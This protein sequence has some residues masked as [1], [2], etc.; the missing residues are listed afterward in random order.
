PEW[1]GGGE[2]VCWRTP[3]RSPAV[4]GAPYPP[5][6]LRWPRAPAHPPAPVL[7]LPDQLPPGAGLRRAVGGGRLVL[8]WFRLHWWEALV[9]VLVGGV[10]AAWFEGN[11]WLQL[12]GVVA[13]LAGWWWWE[14]HTRSCQQI[15]LVPRDSSHPLGLRF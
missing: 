1:G 4:R 5:P 7:P 10:L 12:G 11:R 3:G 6:A 15:R 13:C 9:C 8:G 14:G 2:M